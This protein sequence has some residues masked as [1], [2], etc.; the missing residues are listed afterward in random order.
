MTLPGRAIAV[1]AAGFLLL[2]AVL[3]IWAGLEQRRTGL[4]VGGAACAALAVAVVAMWRRYRR[5]MREVE[6][7]RREMRH[8]AESLRQLLKEHHPSN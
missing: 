6:A 3:L 1:F 5:A 4:V 7:G 8:Q 2:D